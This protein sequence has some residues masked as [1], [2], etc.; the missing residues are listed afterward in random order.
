MPS[1]TVFVNTVGS[2]PS[3]EPSSNLSVIPPLMSTSSS[4]QAKRP[5]QI[6]SDALSEAIL[7]IFLNAGSNCCLGQFSCCGVSNLDAHLHLLLPVELNFGDT[8]WLENSTMAIRIGIHFYLGFVDSCVHHDTRSSKELSMA[9]NE[10]VNNKVLVFA[11]GVDNHG[12]KL[13]KVT[14]HTTATSTESRPV[15]KK[16]NLKTF[17]GEIVDGL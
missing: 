4:T 1:S 14:G 11:K 10:Y 6:V 2:T 12:T 13:V 8:S 9:R 5:L 3:Q 7:R 17:L 15:N 16:H